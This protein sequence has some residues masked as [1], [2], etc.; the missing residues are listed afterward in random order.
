VDDPRAALVVLAEDDRREVLR[1]P[2]LRREREVQAERVVRAAAEAVA[3]VVRRDR[4]GLAARLGQRRP[5][6]S[7]WAWKKFSDPAVAIAAL[8]EISSASVAA[9]T[10]CAKRCTF[11]AP[12]QPMS[13]SHERA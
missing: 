2:L 9:A 4:R 6:R 5:P 3:V 11:P 1:D 8:A 10:I 13:P 12:A 7:W